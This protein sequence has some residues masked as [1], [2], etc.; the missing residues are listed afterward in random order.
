MPKRLSEDRLEVAILT[1][2]IFIF[3][4]MAIG[5][6]IGIWWGVS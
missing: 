1:V 3:Y 6:L 5:S 4:A 2:A